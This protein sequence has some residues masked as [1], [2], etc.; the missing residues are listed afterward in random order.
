MKK[1]AVDRNKKP[2]AKNFLRVAKELIEELNREKAG[3]R[4]LPWKERVTLPRLAIRAGRYPSIFTNIRDGREPPSFRF[5]KEVA[6]S[7][8][9]DEIRTTMAVQK[10]VEASAKDRK[11]LDLDISSL[12]LSKPVD[13]MRVNI[14]IRDV[15]LE[16]MQQIKENR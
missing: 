11:R 13:Q 15:A 8:G 6:R 5:I 2:G 4:K 14:L 1:R 10:M 7:L 16:L 3:G 12:D 9:W